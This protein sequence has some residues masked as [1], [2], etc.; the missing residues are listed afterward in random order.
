MT[1][2]DRV[3][4]GRFFSA[5]AGDA[6]LLSAAMF[7]LVMAV[8]GG[9]MYLGGLIGPDGPVGA[10]GQVVS[11]TSSLLGLVAIVGGPVVAWRLHGRDFSSAMIAGVALGVVATAGA[12]VAIAVLL[13]LT[14]SGIARLIGSQ[15]SAM[16]IALGVLAVSALIVIVRLDFDAVRDMA[17]SRNEHRR[18]D[19]VRLAATAVLVGYSIGVAA[20]VAT[21][22]A[23]EIGEAIPFTI[24]AG[25]IAGLVTA[26]TDMWVRR[27][28]RKQID[29][30]AAVGA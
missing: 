18:I 15:I 19:V 20:L 28:E 12:V 14:V 29:A 4:G 8:A 16:F 9:I 1:S 23:S 25:S 30:G 7:S 5:V 6:F 11:A 13:P 2:S 21:N 3:P 17:P 10:V 24:I 27:D 26:V 22:P